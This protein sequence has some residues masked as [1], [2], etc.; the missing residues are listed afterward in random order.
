MST[1][2]H[3]AEVDVLVPTADRPA[4]LAV[5]L[6]GLAG[7]DHRTFRVLVSDQGDHHA[8]ESPEVTAMARVLGAVGRRVDIERHLPRRGMAEQRHALLARAS[9]PMVLFLDDDVWLEPS[10]L[11]RMAAALAEERCGF[12]GCFPTGLSFGDDRR[13]DVE[14]LLEPWEGS[15]R[16][17]SDEQITAGAERWRLHS[18]ANPTHLHDRFGACRYKVAWVGACVLYDRARLLRVGGFSFWPAMGERDV[19]EEIVPQ[20]LLRRRYG[21]C[22]LLRSGAYHLEAPTTLRE[23]SRD[24]V[25]RLLREELPDVVLPV[26]P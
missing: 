8:R 11:G 26:P 20:L 21:G 16:P 19:G 23:R 5:T 1:T 10:T 12:V 18:A 24:G 4:A 22:A 14:R 2:G 7:Q 15:V 17:E 6:A 3:V 13:S 9:A 25:E